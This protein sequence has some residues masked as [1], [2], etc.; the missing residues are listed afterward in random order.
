[1]NP[2]VKSL[3]T[4]LAALRARRVQLRNAIKFRAGPMSGGDAIDS[5]RAQEFCL[6]ELRSTESRWNELHFLLGREPPGPPVKLIPGAARAMASRSAAAPARRRALP[7][8]YITRDLK[9]NR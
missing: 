6:R 1:M 9:P 4:E 5:R 2:H 8:G 7:T 3:E